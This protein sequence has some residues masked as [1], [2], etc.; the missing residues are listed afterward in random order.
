[1]K[2]II[3]TVSA[4][5]LISGCTD[6]EARTI[7]KNYVSA[8]TAAMTE[9]M[10]HSDQDKNEDFCRCLYDQT[11]RLY[12][13]KEDWIGELKKMESQPENPGF[14]AKT[15]HAASLCRAKEKQ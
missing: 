8:C 7:K 11:A 3:Y 13:S 10:P 5:F 1:M 4:V 12:D 9:N 15:D 2:S 6:F 14:S